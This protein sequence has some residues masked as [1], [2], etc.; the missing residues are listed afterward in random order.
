MFAEGRVFSGT[1]R[2]TADPN[3]STLKAVLEATFDFTI[4]GSNDPIDV[5]AT[6]NGTLETNITNAPRAF[7]IASTRLQGDATLDI[8]QGRLD[9][10]TLKP[11]KCCLE[12]TVIGFKQSNTVV[13]GG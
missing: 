12:S 13:T 11:V 4:V 1:V 10:V 8:S 7:S 6:A 3:N 2:G 5:T 9:P